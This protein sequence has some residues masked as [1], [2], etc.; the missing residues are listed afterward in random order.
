MTEEQRRLVQI[1]R[2]IHPAAIV[3]PHTVVLCP[4]LG[5]VDKYMKY[6]SD[7]REDYKRFFGMSGV[8]YADD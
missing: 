2:L 1:E 6:I 7:H 4:P 8:E 3:G 5:S